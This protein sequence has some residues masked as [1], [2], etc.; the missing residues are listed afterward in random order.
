MIAL[1]QGADTVQIL[2]WLRCKDALPSACNAL[3]APVFPCV[4]LS[5]PSPP[6]LRMAGVKLCP[7]QPIAH[8]DVTGNSGRRLPTELI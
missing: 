7:P 5:I 3:A 4:P 1:T 8:R 2:A 6:L